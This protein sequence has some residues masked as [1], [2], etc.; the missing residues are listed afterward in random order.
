MPPLDSFG[1]ILVVV[2]ITVGTF[3][4]YGLYLQGVQDA[5]SM[6]AVLLGTIEPVMATITTV[7]VLGT[8][9]SVTDFI[10]FGLILGMVVLTA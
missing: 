10:G 6:R 4:A 5:G 3:L 1:W 8:S 9:F 2:G 7:I